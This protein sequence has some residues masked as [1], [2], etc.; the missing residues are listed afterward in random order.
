MF[1]VVIKY[2]VQCLVAEKKLVYTPSSKMYDKW[3]PF[4]QSWW[5]SE[6][7][8]SWCYRTCRLRTQCPRCCYNLK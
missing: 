1:A 7:A 4:S 2:T 3:K 8:R 5:R 6:A